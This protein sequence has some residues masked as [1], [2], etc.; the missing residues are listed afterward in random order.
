[1]AHPVVHFEIPAED[2][3]RM[4]QFY[5]AL[6]DWDMKSDPAMPGYVMVD[7]RTGGQGIDGGL[8]KKQV[9]TRPRSTTWLSNPCPTTPTR[10][11]SSA[12]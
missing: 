8:M 2:L 10:C 6:F 1:M 5:A 11:S 4:R 7:T 3:E 9:P 12:V